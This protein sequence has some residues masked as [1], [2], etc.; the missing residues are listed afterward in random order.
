MHRGTRCTG[1]CSSDRDST[2]CRAFGRA[3]N[4]IVDVHTNTAARCTAING[5][6]TTRLGGTGIGLHGGHCHTITNGDTRTRQTNRAA[7]GTDRGTTVNRQR[8]RSAN[9]NRA[10]R[11]HIAQAQ[12]T[13]VGHGNISPAC[14]QGAA[15]VI[16]IIGRLE[17]SDSAR[18]VQHRT[19][20]C[21]GAC[22]LVDDAARAGG[23]ASESSTRRDG[24]TNG[25]TRAAGEG[26]FS[27]R[28]SRR[29]AQGRAHATGQCHIARG[30]DSGGWQGQCACAAFACLNVDIA[31]RSYCQ[32][33]E[34]QAVCV[35]HG[36]VLARDAD[37]GEV[38]AGVT[39]NNVVRRRARTDGRGSASHDGLGLRNATA[40]VGDAHSAAGVH[41]ID[42]AYRPH[43]QAARVAR[44]RN[45]GHARS[46]KRADAYQ[47]R[48]GER[49]VA[50][51]GKQQATR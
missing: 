27:T 14:Y 19:L 39:Q 26:H 21:N 31:S 43:H 24:V 36:H 32:G 28:N 7:L 22:A 49:I 30:A 10:S 23:A 20:R 46:G 40:R 3:D 11:Q 5:N 50:R 6:G 12:C 9:A 29:S 44:Q 48:G 15:A 38:V 2:I 35:V 18:C 33:A 1:A 16:E 13:C 42:A 25:Q 47:A 37:A 8:T 51:T 34:R 45:G 4:R 41:A 17:G